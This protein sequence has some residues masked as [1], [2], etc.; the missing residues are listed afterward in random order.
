MKSYSFHLSLN[1]T[2]SSET[3]PAKQLLSRFGFDVA[4]IDLVCFLSVIRFFIP[5]KDLWQSLGL[6]HFRLAWT[7]PDRVTANPPMAPEQKKLLTELFLV[8]L[9]GEQEF[10]V[11]TLSL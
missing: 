6:I 9:L 3:E 4:I 8:S 1:S 10:I 5:P 2:R 11:A 7:D